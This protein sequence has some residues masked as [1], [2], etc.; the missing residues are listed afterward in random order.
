MR[1]K[2]LEGRSGSLQNY[3][4]QSV[5]V[6]V[7]VESKNLFNGRERQRRICTCSVQSRCVMG[8]TGGMQKTCYTVQVRKYDE[9]SLPTSRFSLWR[10]QATAV[11]LSSELGMLGLPV[12][13]GFLDYRIDFHW[14]LE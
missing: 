9:R 14:V 8:M 3:L 7:I 6:A 2:C 5:A 13:E 11:D 1:E 4:R 10:R 12:T